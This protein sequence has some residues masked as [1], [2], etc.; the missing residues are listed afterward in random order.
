MLNGQLKSFAATPPRPL[1]SG[2]SDFNSPSSASAGASIVCGVLEDC[3]DCNTGSFISAGP[4]C[5]GWSQTWSSRSCPRR[6]WL[7]SGQTGLITASS[8]PVEKATSPPPPHH[9]P[10]QSFLRCSPSVIRER[11]LQGHFK[12]TPLTRGVFIDSVLLHWSVGHN[13]MDG[14]TVWRAFLAVIFFF[15]FFTIATG[16][17]LKDRLAGTDRLLI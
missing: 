3:S 5:W 2:S 8:L 4:S 1:I 17:D 9:H 13:W 10:Q 12:H 15:S 7:L 14:Q 16:T 11:S 6:Y